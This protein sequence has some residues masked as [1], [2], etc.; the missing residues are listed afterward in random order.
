MEEMGKTEVSALVKKVFRSCREYRYRLWF[1]TGVGI[2]NWCRA[3][4]SLDLIADDTRHLLHGKRTDV[5]WK[6]AFALKDGR[7]GASWIG[8]RSRA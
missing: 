8:L 1:D 6:S 3:T 2:S 7:S 4:G 5:Q